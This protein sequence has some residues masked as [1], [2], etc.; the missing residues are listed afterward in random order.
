MTQKTTDDIFFEKIRARLIASIFSHLPSGWVDRDAS[1]IS[2]R[3]P[4]LEH[5]QPF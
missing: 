4:F 3:Q 1:C 2:Y 5:S